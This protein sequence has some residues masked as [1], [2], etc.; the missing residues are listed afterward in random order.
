MDSGGQKQCGFT[1]VEMITIIVILGI[2]A[3]VAVPRFA[4]NNTFQNRAAAD[5]VAAALRYAQK[6]AI[7]SHS[8]VTVNISA[9]TPE[10]CGSAVAAGVVTCVVNNNVIIT[11]TTSVVFDFMGRRV[12][13]A[14]TT[15]TVGGTTITIEAETGYVH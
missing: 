2:I 15:T 14:Q 7:A 1:L 9:G 8:D 12:P 10:N 11:D 13:N 4:D 5:Q 3:A 6:V